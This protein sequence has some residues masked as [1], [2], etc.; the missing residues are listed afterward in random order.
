MFLNYLKIFKICWV[1]IIGTL[2]IVG[3]A[4]YLPFVSVFMHN[5]WNYNSEFVFPIIITIIIGLILSHFVASYVL[6][7]IHELFYNKAIGNKIHRE[8]STKLISI[9]YWKSKNNIKEA[10]RSISV[11]EAELVLL[12]FGVLLTQF[13]GDWGNVKPRW[14][15]NICYLPTVLVFVISIFTCIYILTNGIINRLISLILS[16]RE[17]TGVATLLLYQLKSY[18]H[19]MKINQKIVFLLLLAVL[20]GVNVLVPLIILSTPL[21]AIL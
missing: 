10:L 15:G 4:Y 13:P 12:I 14:I 6:E 9:K 1:E 16:K 19:Q 17:V 2:A 20:L 5:L 18:W 11:I 7:T 3:S 8:S 21:L